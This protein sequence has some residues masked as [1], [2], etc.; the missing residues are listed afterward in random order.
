MHRR[1]PHR[2]ASLEYGTCFDRGIRCCYH[3]WHF[4]IDGTLLDAPGQGDAA[5]ERLRAR[6]R[7]GAYP[8]IELKGLIF[9]Y[10]GPADDVPAFPL[11]D[12]FGLP[13]MEMVPYVAPFD[14]NWLQ[15]LDAILD[16]IHRSCTRAC[17]GYNF[18]KDLGSSVKL[19]FFD[20]GQW[21]L[22][23]PTRAGSG[24]IC[25]FAR[26]N[27]FCQISRRP[28]RRSQPTARSAVF[29]DGARSTAG[30]CPLDD[31]HS[32]AIGWASFGP[33][34]RSDGVQHTLKVLS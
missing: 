24:T 7:L 15:V 27:W 22:S 16:P 34:G 28:A 17:R 1:R 4:D 33:R 23:V 18:R 21:L 19:D 20:R 11:Y 30:Y 8:V 5:N 2:Q 14:C 10:L 3:G 32:V 29:T 13:G 25:G 31:E 12:T 26:T 9:A 6:V